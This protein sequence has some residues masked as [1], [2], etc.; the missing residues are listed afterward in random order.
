MSSMCNWSQ[1]CFTVRECSQT[2]FFTLV[3]LK[4]VFFKRLFCIVFSLVTCG[5]LLFLLIRYLYLWLKIFSW[6]FQVH[7][8]LDAIFF[9]R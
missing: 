1:N 5:N 2:G 7:F 3:W 9:F 8:N 4:N 6:F